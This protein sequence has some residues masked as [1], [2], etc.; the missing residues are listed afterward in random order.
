MAPALHE[1]IL[2]S[3]L[4]MKQAYI[5]QCG[6]DGLTLLICEHLSSGAWCL[7]RVLRVMESSSHFFIPARLSG[8]MLSGVRVL[9][10][11][12]P[13]CTNWAQFICKLRALL[14]PA[15]R[16]VKVQEARW[17]VLREVSMKRIPAKEATSTLKHGLFGGWLTPLK[18]DGVRQLGWWNSWKVIKFHGSKPPTSGW[19]RVHAK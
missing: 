15:L 19:L 18:N 11:Y 6:F 7:C 10:T 14:R 13:I 12:G 9:R 5:L 8:F 4:R 1:V 3:T 17:F 2:I 16:G